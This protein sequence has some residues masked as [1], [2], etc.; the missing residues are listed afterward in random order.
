MRFISLSE[1]HRTVRRIDSTI[2]EGNAGTEDENKVDKDKGGN[3][4]HDD[5]FL[6]GAAGIPSCENNSEMLL[7][8]DNRV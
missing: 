8:E 1:S 6:A 3:L 2:S 4:I 5:V 7:R